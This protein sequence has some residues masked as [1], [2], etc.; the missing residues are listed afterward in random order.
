M[1]VKKALWLF[2]ILKYLKNI[3]NTAHSDVNTL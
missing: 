3:N 1:V 2:S